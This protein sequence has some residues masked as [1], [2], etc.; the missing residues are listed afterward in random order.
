MCAVWT[1]SRW[2]TGIGG[3]EG[4]MNVSPENYTPNRFDTPEYWY[5]I[6]CVEIIS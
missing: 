6:Y 1:M 2:E 4:G 5:K 3:K